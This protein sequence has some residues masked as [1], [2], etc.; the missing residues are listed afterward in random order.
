[1]EISATLATVIVIVI[2]LA[3]IFLGCPI[4]LSLGV[5]GVI[6]ILITRGIVGLAQSP[7]M[8]FAQLDNFVLV[9]APLYILMG[10]VLFITGIG[11]DLYEAFSRWLHWL[12][13]GLAV[14][15]IFACAV[16][17]AMSGVSIVAVAVIGVMAVPEM[18]KR[19]YDPSVAVGSVTAAGALAMLIPPSL[20]FILY[21]AEAHV[22]V[23]R[24]FI[25]GIIPGIVLAIMMS[26]YVVI[27]VILKPD[28][29]PRIAERITWKA[30]FGS[31]SRVWPAVVLI[32]L[33]LGTIYTGV[34]TPTE[35]AGIGAAGSY[36]IAA[37]VYRAVNWK[38]LRA[39][40]TATMRITGMICIIV[41]CAMAFGQFLN[42]VRIPEILAEFCVGVPWPRVWV[43]M[44]LMFF[45]IILGMFIDG[46][47][48]VIVTTPI[49]LPAIIALGYDPLWYGIILVLNLE[50][51]VI[52]PPVGL[53]LYTMKSITEDIDMGQII[54][55]IL[56]YVGIE[57]ACLL[58]FIFSPQ[59]TLWLPGLMG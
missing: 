48:M 35:S 37:A 58:I 52:T 6:G 11:R 24:L 40:L 3:L 20:L 29:A 5:S 46:A 59:L 28:L 4:F 54:R 50:M 26:I 57:F 19:G 2:V 51:A 22:S 10:E 7:A 44:L 34:C 38:T 39:T 13:G 41:A 14:A 56:P 45:L 8:M 42:T 21:G 23:A 30:R 49:L 16:F 43:L 31:L 1:M 55:G 25:G 53:N 18:L 32:V 27:R 12:P 36:I 47:S 15:S 33:V 9:A 17:G